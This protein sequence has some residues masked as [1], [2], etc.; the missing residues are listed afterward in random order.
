M[1]RSLTFLVVVFFVVAS[2]VAMAQG[3]LKIGRIE[4][5]KVLEIMP[6]RI[7][8]QKSMQEQTKS[9]QD[10]LQSMQAD[11]N[12]KMQFYAQKKDSLNELVRQSK[13]AELVDMQKRMDDFRNKAQEELS[14]K[15]QELTKPIYERFK[16][17]VA[18][19]AKEQKFSAI[20][21]ANNFL[22]VNEDVVDVTDAVKAKLNLK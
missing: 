6:E 2:Q 22:F 21:D 10:E 12:K 11:Y 5:S 19:V 1:K 18:D 14:K 17:A 9:L 4:T 15:E 20:L 3:K 16:K 8:A 13:E 7:A